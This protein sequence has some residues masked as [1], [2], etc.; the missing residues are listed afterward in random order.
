[1]KLETLQL[2][3]RIPVLF[4]GDLV[5]SSQMTVYLSLNDQTGISNIHPCFLSSFD[6]SSSS[7]ITY[8]ND[9]VQLS[10]TDVFPV[11]LE[12]FTDIHSACD[13]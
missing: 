1:M 3:R 4:S 8:C 2:M 7:N 12:V 6:Y 10:F 9:K 11:L 5:Y 13:S